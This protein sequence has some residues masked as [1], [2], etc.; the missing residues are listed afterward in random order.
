MLNAFDEKAAALWRRRGLLPSRDDP[1]VLFQSIAAILA[2]LS[3]DTEN[4]QVER[5]PAQPDVKS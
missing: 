2:S 5:Q 4:R 3:S 1:L